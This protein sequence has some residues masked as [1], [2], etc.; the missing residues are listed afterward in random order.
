MWDSLPNKLVVTLTFALGSRRLLTYQRLRDEEI[1]EALSARPKER[2][3]GV[4]A[5]DLNNFRKRVWII[6]PMGRLSLTA[7]GSTFKV[8]RRQQ[9]AAPIRQVRGQRKPNSSNKAVQDN[10]LKE[11]SS[12]ISFY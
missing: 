5:N 9:R 7:I 10:N 11:F 6:F 8:S 12:H 1:K 3:N 4:K 2:I